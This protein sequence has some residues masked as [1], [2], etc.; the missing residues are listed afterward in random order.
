MVPW[1][2]GLRFAVTFGSLAWCSAQIRA[3]PVR[4]ACLDPDV[5]SSAQPGGAASVVGLGPF[6]KIPYLSPSIARCVPE[7]PAV[8]EE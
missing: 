5:A 2:C 6:V 4:I 3:Q 7:S 1:L 8:C